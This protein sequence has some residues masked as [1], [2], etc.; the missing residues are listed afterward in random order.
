[1]KTEIFCPPALFFLKD[2]PIRAVQNGF[3]PGLMADIYTSTGFSRNLAENKA[4]FVL[5]LPDRSNIV[6]EVGFSKETV[7]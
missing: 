6:I 3:C 4:D 5:N 7:F 1:M 2:F